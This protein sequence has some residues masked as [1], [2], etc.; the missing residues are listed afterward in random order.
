M[1]LL[2]AHHLCEKMNVDLMCAM[3]F[4]PTASDES[5]TALQTCR[6]PDEAYAK[7]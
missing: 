1:S 4:F 2:N 7:R 5:A 6:I 3:R